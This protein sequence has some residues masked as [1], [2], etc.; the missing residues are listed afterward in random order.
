MQQHMQQQQQQQQQPP[1]PMQQQ[2][3]QHTP[4]VSYGKRLRSQTIFSL[5]VPVWLQLQL[6]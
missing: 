6:R 5:R 2:Y 1:K 4:Q 3:P